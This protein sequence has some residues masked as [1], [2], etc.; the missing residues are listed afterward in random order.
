MLVAALLAALTVVAAVVAGINDWQL[1]RECR[2]LGNRW[3]RRKG[4]L[5]RIDECVSGDRHIPVGAVFGQGC[6]ACEC[7]QYYGAV[8]RTGMLCDPDVNTACDPS[9]GDCAFDPGCV[10][11]RAYHTLFVPFSPR[12][13]CGCDGQ[14]FVSAA[15]TKP[16]RHV[17]VCGGKA[18]PGASANDPLK[19]RR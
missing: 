2:A 6:Y 1:S 19:Q 8:C 16:Y 13:Y 4:C 14:T 11:P 5:A 12:P 7:T 3:D 9:S 10:L 17:G 15:P 18:A